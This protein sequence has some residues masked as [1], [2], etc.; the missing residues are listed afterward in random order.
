MSSGV[1][2][3]YQL[4]Y[5]IHV[6]IHVPLRHNF[7][8]LEHACLHLRVAASHLYICSRSHDGHGV[9]VCETLLGVSILPL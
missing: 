9:A 7:L 3:L 1:C 2:V 5:T 6:V 4:F 8:R